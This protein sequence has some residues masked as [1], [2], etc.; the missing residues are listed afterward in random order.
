[1]PEP[2]CFVVM[3]FGVK[4]DGR[5]GSVDFD[6]VYTDLLAPAIGAAKLYR[7]GTRPRR[8]RAG[9]DLRPVV[10]GARSVSVAFADGLL[11][12]LL[13]YGCPVTIEVEDEAGR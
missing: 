8:S 4:P 9:V 7:A 3:P 12:A 6:A 1:V 11:V 13:R 5:G 10:A 2:L